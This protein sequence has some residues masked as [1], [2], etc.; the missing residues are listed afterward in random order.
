MAQKLA[1]YRKFVVAA[2]AAAVN[3]AAIFALPINEAEVQAVL[4]VFDVVA[5][6]LV[7]HVPNR[8]S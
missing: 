1:E 8:P 7:A 5:A 2:G 4:S 6:Y 3:I